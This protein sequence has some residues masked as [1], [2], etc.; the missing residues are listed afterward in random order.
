MHTYAHQALRRELGLILSVLCR[1][2]L[3]CRWSIWEWVMSH[4]WMSHVT[5]EWVMSHRNKSCDMWMSH[6][7]HRWQCYVR[8][9]CL[10]DDSWGWVTSHM[11]MSH[12]S[13]MNESRHTY[14]WV[15]SHIVMLWM[16]HVTH[17]NESCHTCEWVMSHIWMSPVSQ[18][19]KSCLTYGVATIS[20]LLKIIGLFCRL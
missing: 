15:M 20:R 7:T 14:E 17:V 13:H 5:C 2:L 16:S 9:C 8:C 11:W 18:M 4:I 12:V 6:V 1:L 3:S 19:N 10:A